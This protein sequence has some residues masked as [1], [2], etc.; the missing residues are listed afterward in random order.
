MQNPAWR[1][2]LTGEAIETG[3]VEPV[4]L[5]STQQGM[6]PGAADL[7]AKAVQSQQVRRNC[8]VRKVAIQDPLKPLA[9]EGHRFMPPLVELIAVN[10]ACMRFLAVM[11]TSWN[12]PCW[13][14]PQQCVNP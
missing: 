8:M 10:V 13:S 14:V 4:P 3:P 7:T 6:P 11:R 5:T 1:D 12:F 9:N 2:V